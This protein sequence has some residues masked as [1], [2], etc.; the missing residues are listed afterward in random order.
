MIERGNEKSGAVFSDDERYRYRL[1]RC[2]DESKPRC[3]F[4]ML[5][6]STATHEVSDPTVT[7]ALLYAQDWGYGALD[8]TNIHALRST[9]PK[10]LYRV[11]NPTGEH[12]DHFIEQV[13]LKAGIVVCAWGQHGHFRDRGLRVRSKLGSAG[14]LLYYLRMG[15]RYQ[16]WHPLYLPKDLKPT[17]W[18]LV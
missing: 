17:R 2:W 10:E 7:R 3:N 4:L 9:D 6:P 5:N 14:V 16:P 12:N 18:V 13:A 1:W 15:A 11:G 8:V